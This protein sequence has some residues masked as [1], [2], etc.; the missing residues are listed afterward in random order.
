MPQ[1][2]AKVLVHIVYS[3]KGRRPWLQAEEIRNQLYAY[4][5]VILRDN[6]DTPALI[7]GGAEDHIHALCLLSRKFA[8]KDVIEE[9]KTETTKWIKK[10]GSQYADFHWQ[11]GYGIFSV[12]ESNVD[13]VR[14]YIANQIEHHKKMS[15]QDEFRALCQRHGIE[16]DER[17]VWD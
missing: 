3:T 16:I 11:S 10:Q 1:S 6:V 14:S 4:N 5:A 17:Y 7:I 2:L 9:S 15:F 13:Q 12:S 8:I